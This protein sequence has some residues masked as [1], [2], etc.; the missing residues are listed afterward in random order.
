LCLLPD[1][2][3]GGTAPSSVVVAALRPGS[4]S[5]YIVNMTTTQ[6]D[7]I[8]ASACELYLSDGLEGFSMRK[9]AKTV[10][11]TA[12]ALYRHFASK[13]E[14]LMAVMAEAYR[15]FAQYLYRALGG[16]TPEERFGRAAMEYANF[17]LE[18]PE[19]YEMLYVSPHHLGIDELPDNVAEVAA[20]TGQFWEDRVRECVEAGILKHDDPDALSVTMW[21]HAHGLISL[22]L[23]GICPMLEGDFRAMYRA[24]GRRLM[25][26]LA[27]PAWSPDG[28][29][30]IDSDAEVEKSLATAKT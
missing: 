8:L 19:M 10:G 2:A 14:V 11:V 7:K 25:Q 28:V 17:A 1:R 30:A 5:V 23:K 21:A 24:S 15:M 26:G 4:K 29:E 27:G 20:A 12:P 18:H 3:A 6:Q 13:E 9:L 16:R 22:Y